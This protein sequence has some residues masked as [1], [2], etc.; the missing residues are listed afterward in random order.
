MSELKTVEENKIQ[1]LSEVELFSKAMRNVGDSVSI[2]TSSEY[3]SYTVAHVNFQNRALSWI[4]YSNNEEGYSTT[5]V[6]RDIKH[7]MRRSDLYDIVFTLRDEV[8]VRD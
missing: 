4:K 8:S 6:I 2:R 5:N 7:I 3:E 1:D